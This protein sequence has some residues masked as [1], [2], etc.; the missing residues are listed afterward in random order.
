MK[1][2]L[3]KYP[4]QI[5]LIISA[6]I[7]FLSLSFPNGQD[8]CH[9]DKCGLF[10]SRSHGHDA[11]WHLSIVSIAFKQFPLLMST[12]AGELLKGYNYFYDLFLFL[13][14]KLGISFLFSYFRLLPLIWFGFFTFL[15]IRIAQK[16][17]KAPSFT[18]IFLFFSYF[19]GSFS[20][21]FTLVR[22]KTIWGSSGILF[23]PIENMMLNFQFGLSLLGILWI[24]LKILEKKQDI[25]TQT[26]F[27]LL[28]FINFGLKFYG[29]FVTLILVLS[30]LILSLRKSKMFGLWFG[31]TLLSAIGAILIFYSPFDSMKNGSIFIFSPFASVHHITEE[32]NL[33]YLKKITA[34]RYAQIIKGINI[35]F[36]I[37]ELFN[38]LI[39]L[40]FYLGVRFFGILFFMYRLIR[41]KTSL[42]DRCLSVAI[43]CSIL[44]TVLFV[45]KGE[46]TNIYQFFY[47]TVF[48]STFYLVQLADSLYRS[49]TLFF[50][51]IL[52]LMII[53]AVPT[54]IDLAKNSLSS[55]ALTYLPREELEALIWLKKQ[56]EGVVFSPLYNKDIGQNMSFPKPL[57]AWGDTAYVSAFS[58]QQ[59]YLTDIWMEQITGIDYKKRMERVI[60]NDCGILKEINYIY[61]NNDFKINRSLFDCSNR[62]EFLWGNRTATIYRVIK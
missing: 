39:F 18:A 60:K 54:T 43:L 52:I 17:N 35:K 21:Y 7:L 6:L 15:L 13:L 55:T 41:K 33:F 45:Q 62:L 9:Q 34:Y 56:P 25:R 16:I 37:I 50:N 53:M 24:L 20:Y 29:G 58:G 42:F 23:H 32:P 2:I 57:Y 31:V 10:F 47:Y 11:I 51:T 30:N 1:A 12:Y 3:K 38:L 28:I 19:T 36:I 27:C 44:M 46:W 48:L 5:L 22:D 26:I 40:F 49:K 59:H 14:S 4:T 8:Q 61:F